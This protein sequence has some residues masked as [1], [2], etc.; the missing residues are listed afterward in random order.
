MLGLAQRGDG[1]MLKR[2]RGFAIAA[3]LLAAAVSAADAASLP[4]FTGPA[5]TNPAMNPT[6]LGDL[7]AT[8]NAINSGVTPGSMATFSANRNFLDNGGMSVAQRGTAAATGGT[9]SGCPLTT[10]V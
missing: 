4:Q 7:N 6:I 10:Y 1:P 3:V 9:T 8:I 5:G 2:F